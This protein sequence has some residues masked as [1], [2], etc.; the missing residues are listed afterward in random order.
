M[1]HTLRYLQ[2]TQ[3]HKFTPHPK[4]TLGSNKEVN[5]EA[6]KSNNSSRVQE[7]EHKEH[8]TSETFWRKQYP[9]NRLQTHIHTDYTSA[10]SIATGIG[11]M[12]RNTIQQQI[13]ID[14]PPAHKNQHAR[15]PCRH[16][17]NICH[18]RRL[19]QSSLQCWAFELK[20]YHSLRRQFHK[21]VSQACLQARVQKHQQQLDACTIHTSLLTPWFRNPLY[22][23]WQCYLYHPGFLT[24]REA[25]GLMTTWIYSLQFLLHGINNSEWNIFLLHGI[26][27]FACRRTLV[28]L[29]PWRRWNNFF[30]SPEAVFAKQLGPTTCVT[31]TILPRWRTGGQWSR[32]QVQ[33]TRV[34]Q[35]AEWQ[36]NLRENKSTTQYVDTR[37]AFKMLVIKDDNMTWSIAIDSTKDWWYTALTKAEWDNAIEKSKKYWFTVTTMDEYNLLLDFNNGW[38]DHLPGTEEDQ[39]VRSSQ[40][41]QQ[42]IQL[43]MTISTVTAQQVDTE[44]M[45]W[46]DNDE[47]WNNA[48]FCLYR[49]L[50]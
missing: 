33:T 44:V 2:G 38:S 6:R 13:H 36:H 4:T 26:R 37:I 9:T 31:W 41:S 27:N 17:D 50:P 3:D 30:F 1:K 43:E 12:Y 35:F 34:G 28:Q 14:I 5:N 39:W 11:Q 22:R 20:N 8:Y 18:S 24:K 49:F 16:T 7:E 47:S 46:Q 40:W 19:Q 48:W 23:Q 15:Q 21:Q 25:L 10:K 32:R 45:L 42:W 29:T